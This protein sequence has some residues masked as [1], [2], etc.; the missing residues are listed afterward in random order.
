MFFFRVSFSTPES[1]LGIRVNWRDTPMGEVRRRLPL[2]HGH[3]RVINPSERW[4]E[5][6]F[7]LQAPK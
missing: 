5:N 4:G 3:G 6:Y 2:V 1:C 7:L